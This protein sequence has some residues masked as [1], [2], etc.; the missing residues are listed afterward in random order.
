MT[1]IILTREQARVVARAQAKVQVCD[2]DGNVLGYL[3]PV[4]FTP[5]EIAEAKRALASA[6]R[7]Y[8]TAQV[9]EYLRSLEQ[10]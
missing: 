5:E 4:D 3:E 8:T 7:R 10:K 6:E 2:P 9:L 1:Q